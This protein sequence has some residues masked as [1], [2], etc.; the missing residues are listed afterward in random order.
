MTTAL[1]LRISDDPR[2][3]ELGVD[4]QRELCESVARTRGWADVTVYVD[5]DISAT[6]G[7]HRPGYVAMMAAVD[8]GEIK[9]VVCYH[10]S[11]VWRNRRETQPRGLRMR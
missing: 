2:N 3:T 8:R 10:L 5:N 1:Y 9:R 6:N 4:R 7:K 11:R